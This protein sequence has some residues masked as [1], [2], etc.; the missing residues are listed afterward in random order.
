MP[1]L[2]NLDP[3]GWKYS[4][5]NAVLKKLDVEEAPAYWEMSGAYEYLQGDN[6]IVIP[7]GKQVSQP[8]DLRL[9]GRDGAQLSTHITIVV[10][11]GASASIIE[12]QSG[13]GRYWKDIDLHIEVGANARLSHYRFCEEDPFCVVTERTSIA[14]ERD[15]RYNLVVINGCAGFGRSDFSVKMNGAGAECDLSGLTL[16]S[17]KQHSDTTICIEHIAPHCRS[18][19]FFKNVLNDQSRGVY[20]GKI[21]VHKGAQKTDGYQLSN[22]LLLSALAEMDV[23]PE[24]EIYA[25]DVKC[26][27]GT[28]TGQLDETPLFYL[29]SRGIPKED[30]RRLLLEAFL[31]EVLD[32]IRDE[33]VREM[34]EGRV[35]L[36]LK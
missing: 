21:L 30:A 15:A 11:D 27:H 35:K 1:T 22:N 26:S 25:D 3:E 5:I 23:K 28:T 13:E 12:R 34:F 20:Q 29:M 31:V 19:Q 17:G 14:M 6:K 9:S 36:W 32:K 7:R 33:Q 24:L 8:I 10:E 4:N 2:P 16:L 18:S